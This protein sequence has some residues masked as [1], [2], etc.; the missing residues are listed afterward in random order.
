M[1]FQRRWSN[2]HPYPE[3]ASCTRERNG[4][5]RF[6]PIRASKHGFERYRW[7]ITP[8]S[9]LPQEIIP[10]PR[11]QNPSGNSNLLNF[12]FLFISVII[13]IFF[14]F[15]LFRCFDVCVLFVELGFRW[16]P[17]SS[18]N[19][20]CQLLQF[21]RLVSVKDIYQ[22]NIDASISNSQRKR[23]LLRFCLTDGCS[24]VIAIEYLPMPAISE[25]IASGTKVCSLA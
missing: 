9:F 8:W 1:V 2:S 23:R 22:S 14:F 6:H 7:K 21:E 18:L 16:I 25:E 15:F 17:L 13:I 4:F 10:S 5:S 19:L 11:P 20:N 12:F 24:Q 3:Q